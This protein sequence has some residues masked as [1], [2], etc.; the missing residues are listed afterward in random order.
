MPG[1]LQVLGKYFFID[2]WFLSQRQLRDPL[3]FL[4]LRVW[5]GRQRSPGGW[6]AEGRKPVRNVVQQARP[7]SAPR[8]ATSRLQVWREPCT[9]WGLQESWGGGVRG[10]RQTENNRMMIILL[11][12]RWASK[13]GLVSVPFPGLHSARPS[14]QLP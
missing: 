8:E 9:V 10:H 3:Q 6:R 2:F 13:L 4:P 5:G 11:S 7:A 14:S 12:P 1:E